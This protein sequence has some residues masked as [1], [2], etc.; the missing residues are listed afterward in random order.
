MGTPPQVDLG[1]RSG[2]STLGVRG[3]FA[4]RSFE[5]GR[6]RSYVLALMFVVGC[7][8]GNSGVS[9]TGGSQGT[10]GA[11]GTGRASATGGATGTGGSDGTGGSSGTGGASATG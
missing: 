11:T 3:D 1:A 7:G 8:S 9:G 5:D 4:M 10:G 2:R 6:G